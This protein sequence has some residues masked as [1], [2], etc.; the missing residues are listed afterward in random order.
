MYYNKNEVL[1]EVCDKFVAELEGAAKN[2]SLE[3]MEE[4]IFGFG[5]K[6][7]SGVN[8]YI[9]AMGR[10]RS[11]TLYTAELG[12]KFEKIVKA[13]ATN[14]TRSNRHYFVDRKLRQLEFDCTERELAAIQN[15]IDDLI[16]DYDRYMSSA[17]K[18]YRY[19]NGKPAIDSEAKEAIASLFEFRKL[20]SVSESLEE[21]AD[22]R[23]FV[24]LSGS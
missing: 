11:G 23:I 13:H 17:G 18:T 1:G 3:D 15:D 8:H 19:R 12:D 7:G 10:D 22:I 2:E 14:V 5:K 9:G 20:G 6:K 4:G 21:S 16:I 24:D